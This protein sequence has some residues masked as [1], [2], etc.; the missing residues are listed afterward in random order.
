MTK[1]EALERCLDHWAFLAETGAGDKWDYFKKLHTPDSEIPKN[2][3]Y[4]CEYVYNKQLIKGRMDCKLCPLNDYAWELWK[5]QP[6]SECCPCETDPDSIYNEWDDCGDYERD[7]KA[8][9]SKMVQAIT[10]A[11]EDLK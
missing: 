8:A 10:Q 11:L 6:P 7:L 1:K 4:L 2:G 5:I 3:C 9:A